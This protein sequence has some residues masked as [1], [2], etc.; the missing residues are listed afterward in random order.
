MAYA[1]AQS[2]NQ[3]LV[4]LGAVAA[5]HLA[6]GYALVT[7]LAA[8]GIIDEVPT[9]FQARNIAVDVP[10]DPPPPPPAREETPRVEQDRPAIVTPAIN[11]DTTTPARLPEIADLLPPVSNERIVVPPPVATPRLATEPARPRND[12]GS[13]VSEA[14]YSGRAIRLGLEGV[15]RFT[16]TIGTDGRVSD[17]RITGSSGH[18]ELDAA[19]CRLIAKR[20]RF[21]PARNGDGDKVTGS[22]SSAVRWR[23]SD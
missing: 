11:L 1:Q 13:W 10:A 14:D 18:D 19:T 12:P 7:G 2:P 16:L 22:Y 9:L 8:A 4:T 17:C 6:A 21:E 15:T 5:L 3:K 23:I 20:A